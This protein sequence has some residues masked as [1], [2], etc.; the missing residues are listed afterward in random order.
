VLNQL[1]EK[2]EL[3]QNEW[4][5]ITLIKKSGTSGIKDTTSS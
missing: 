4:S 1:S 3:L 2:E 5:L